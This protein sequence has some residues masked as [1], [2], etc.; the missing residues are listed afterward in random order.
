MRKKS[1][2]VKAALAQFIA[3]TL[4]NSFAPQVKVK[5]YSS[6]RESRLEKPKDKKKEEIQ[7]W[8]KKFWYVCENKQFAERVVKT[9]GDKW[10]ILK[11]KD[12]AECADKYNEYCNYEGAQER[13]YK[14]PNSWINDGGYDNE[15]M[16]KQEGGMSY[17]IE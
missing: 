5:A 12:P 10:E 15:I 17:D 16:K 8:F 11:D 7:Q 3:P 6:P 14:Q 13:R 1:E 9:I 4:G 2:V